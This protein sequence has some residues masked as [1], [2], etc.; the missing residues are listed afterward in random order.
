LVKFVTRFKSLGVTAILTSESRS[1]YF[2]DDITELGFSPVADNLV[3]LRYV[4]HEGT[5]S[6]AL[7][8]VKSRGSAH[9]RG[10]HAFEVGSGGVRIG[11]RVGSRTAAGGQA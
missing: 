1:L 6:P 11:D 10:T 2:G 9:D 3:M 8:V 7:R 5:L 4:E